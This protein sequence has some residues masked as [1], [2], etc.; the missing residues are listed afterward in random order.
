MT[1]QSAEKSPVPVVLVC[2]IDGALAQASS[3]AQLA[4]PEA[5]VVRH[6]LDPE[7]DV[8]TR[9]VHELLGHIETVEIKLDHACIAC[10]IRADIV[11]TLE[12]LARSRRWPA[13][14]A[15]LPATTEPMQIYHALALSHTAADYVRIGSILAGLTGPS[16]IADCLG[17]QY[18]TDRGLPVRAD[19]DRGIAAAV[20]PRKIYGQSSATCALA[21]SGQGSVLAA[22]AARSGVPVG[23][24]RGSI[25]HRRSG[26]RRSRTSHV[27][28]FHRWPRRGALRD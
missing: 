3:A 13:I 18:L 15:E 21:G 7:R 19:D 26:T 11:P 5:V 27:T 9:T 10:A 8:L 23:R 4:L 6:T 17:S 20:S 14:I 2:G 25:M 22:H 28:N 12:K 24:C 16:I 1:S